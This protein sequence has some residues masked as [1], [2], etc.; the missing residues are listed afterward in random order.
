VNSPA[1][2]TV[3]GKKGPIAISAL[4]V[5][6]VGLLALH[7]GDVRTPYKDQA[8]IW[9]VCRGITGPS[10][11]PGK[12]YTAAE[13]NSLELAYV[14]N[15][16]LKMSDIVRVPLAFDEWI[17]YG[18]FTYNTGFGALRSSTLIKKLNAGDHVGACKEM[19]R[20][21]FIK[22]NGKHVNCRDPKYKCGGIPTRR[23]F[24]VQM[25]LKAQ[26]SDK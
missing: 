20:W 16:L 15:M 6:L 17:A 23:D 19:G 21:T 10:V 7:E 18:H 4:A 22:I 11:I 5:S 3:R 8:G 25:C 9:T 2:K 26:G 1:P 13:C 12:T 14:S 24:E